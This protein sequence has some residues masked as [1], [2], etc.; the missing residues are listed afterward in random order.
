MIIEL[1]VG[2]QHLNAKVNDKKSLFKILNKIICYILP[3]IA[4]LVERRTVVGE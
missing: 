4:Q 3:S 1:G 2:A